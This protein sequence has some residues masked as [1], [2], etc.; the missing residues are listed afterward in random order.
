MLIKSTAKRGQKRLKLAEYRV[1]VP[2]S[3]SLVFESYLVMLGLSSSKG[4]G[5]AIS[6]G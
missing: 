4:D 1:I 6:I 5:P 3:P 2:A